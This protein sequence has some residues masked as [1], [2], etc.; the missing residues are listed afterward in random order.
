MADLTN[1]P[2][3]TAGWDALINANNDLLRTHL[4]E[5]LNGTKNTGDDAIVDPTTITAQTLTDSTT[6]TPGITINDGTATYSQ[7][8][9]NDN[10]AS[11]LTEINSLKTDLTATR[12][13]LVT[14]LAYLRKTGGLGLIAD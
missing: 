14:L 13:T 12:A 5:M 9:T 3:N 11:L 6:G 10:N 2:N 4:L 1:I 7:T 8:I